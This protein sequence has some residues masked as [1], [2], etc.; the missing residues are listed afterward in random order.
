MNTTTPTTPTTPTTVQPSYNGPTRQQRLFTNTILALIAGLLFAMMLDRGQGSL[1]SQANAQHQPVQT[2]H[3]GSSGNHSASNDEPGDATERVTAADQRKVMIAEL[4]SL[5]SRM[6]HVEAVLSKG[7]TVKV[8]EMPPMQFPADK[9]D[10]KGDSKPDS[11][12]D[13][14]KQ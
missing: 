11:K 1:I 12:A 2:V 9:G 3:G 7:L 10:K 4:R 14:K 13:A 8:S 6:E 5:N